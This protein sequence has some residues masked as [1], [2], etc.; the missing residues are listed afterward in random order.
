MEVSMNTLR[1]K[2]LGMA[3]SVVF[4]PLTATAV[5]IFEVG[6]AG[7][8]LGTAQLVPGG[9]T[10]IQGN[11]G[12]GEADLFKFSWGGGAFYVN[13]VG[14]LWDSQ[15]FL[16]NAAGAGVQANDDGIAYAGPAYLQIAALAAGDYYLA[17]SAYDLDPYSSSGVIFQSF[18]YGA[19]YG[20]QN[21]DPLSYWAG[22]TGAGGAYT[23]SFQ[24]V[25]S[26]GKPTGT[27]TPVGVPDGGAT[28]ALLGLGLSGIGLARRK[29][30][31]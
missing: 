29:L 22:G 16:F 15:L 12:S 18:P 20:P 17:I 8:T 24:Q 2:L 5:T 3:A 21:G 1:W 13:S 9:A 7:Q 25:T 10:A 31:R 26:E 6:D 4:V 14:T 11:L 19:L 30:K 23:I 28:V 27:S